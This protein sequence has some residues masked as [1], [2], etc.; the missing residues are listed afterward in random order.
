[1]IWRNIRGGSLKKLAIKKDK[2]YINNL[3][4][5]EQSQPLNTCTYVVVGMV[6]AD[7]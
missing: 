2:N 3:K 6:A 5:E 1:M 7:W 4:W